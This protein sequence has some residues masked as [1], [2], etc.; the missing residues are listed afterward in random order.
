MEVTRETYQRLSRERDEKCE[1]RMREW[2]ER[3]GKEEKG[4]GKKRAAARTKGMNT[5]GL[6]M[7][8]LKD[9]YPGFY[10][11][12]MIEDRLVACLYPTKFK[13]DAEAL[14]TP[15]CECL[16]ELAVLMRIDQEEVRGSC[17]L[18]FSPHSISFFQLL[19]TQPYIHSIHTLRRQQQQSTA[20]SSQPST[21]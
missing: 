9:I 2:K 11:V 20:T 13:L 15:M 18:P 5:S 17:S 7:M 4:G 1:E 21:G 14:R 3:M 12:R 6:I 16:W 19:I 8:T 10:I